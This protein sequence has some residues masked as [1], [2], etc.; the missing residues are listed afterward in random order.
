MSLARTPNNIEILAAKSEIDSQAEYLSSHNGN[1]NVNINSSSIPGITIP[2]FDTILATYDD[3]TFTE[4]Y[5]YQ[6]SGS[7]VATV[8][9]IYTDATKNKLVSIVRT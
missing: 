2:E 6:K 9:V 3:I 5:T 4:V 8:T 1:L 7:T